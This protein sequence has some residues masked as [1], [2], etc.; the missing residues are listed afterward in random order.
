MSARRKRIVLLGATGSIGESTRRVIAAHRDRLELVAVAGRGV[1][2][3]P[4]TLGIRPERIRVSPVRSEGAVAAV[5][6]RKS[7]HI[8]GQYLLS[9]RLPGTGIGFKAKVGHE[10]G[11]A[12]PETG[13]VWATLPLDRIALFGENGDRLPA[14]FPSVQHAAAIA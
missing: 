3:G 2:A 13:D 5:L 10:D 11:A 14:A 9:L 4:V 1:E 7:I 6:E 8:G 12:L